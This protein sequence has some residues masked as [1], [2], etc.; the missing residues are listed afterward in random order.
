LLGHIL[1]GEA[2]TVR[3]AVEQDEA[4]L[5]RGETRAVSVRLAEAPGESRAGHLLRAVP[6][7][8][9]KLPSAALGE[10]AGGD[11]AVD[12]A[13]KD[14][15]QAVAPVFIFDIGVDDTV[16]ERAGAG[17]GCASSMAGRPSPCSGGDDSSSS[18]CG[19]S[20]P[21]HD[22]H[23]S[24][25]MPLPGLVWGSYPERREPPQVRWPWARAPTPGRRRTQGGG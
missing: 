3:V 5:V 10:H 1:T 16:L 18:S 8:T 13:D 11:I 17:H 19:S 7:A 20:T 4:A 6:A 15:Q 22:L 12:P 2:A 14:H 9:E 24:S 25:R 23:L 21:T